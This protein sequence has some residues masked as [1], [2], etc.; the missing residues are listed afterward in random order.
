LAVIKDRKPEFKN[1]SIMKKLNLVCTFLT[2]IFIISNGNLQGQNHYIGIM[3]E[4]T[5]ATSIFSDFHY[6]TNPPST[7]SLSGRYA[8]TYGFDYTIIFNSKTYGFKTGLYY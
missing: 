2:I 8:N 1:N 3:Y 4:P 7:H 5:I 6:E